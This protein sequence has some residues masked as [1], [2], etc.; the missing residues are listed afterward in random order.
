MQYLKSRPDDSTVYSSL[1]FVVSA[2]NAMKSKNPL[3]E[4]FLVQLDV[5]LEGTGIRAMDNTKAGSGLSHTVKAMVSPFTPDITRFLREVRK[6]VANLIQQTYC[7]DN[8]ECTPVYNIRQSQ[9]SGT[10]NESLQDN[11][12]SRT[13]ARSFLPGATT[14]LPSRHRDSPI[15]DS[16]RGSLGSESQ[17]FFPHVQS[18]NG[19]VELVGQ[20]V[21]DG[22]MDF[23]PDFGVGER[24]PP[25][26][27]PTP[28]TLNSSSNT[29]YSLSGIDNPS[30]DKKHPN[31]AS[32]YPSSSSATSIDKTH[33]V[34]ISPV[35]T[36]ASQILDMGSI[37]GQG[38]PASSAGPMGGTGA[39]YIFNMAN[40]WDM[41][42][43]GQDMGNLD[44]EN[45]NVEAIS[46]AQWAQ[47]LHTENGSG[48]ENWRPS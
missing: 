42:T 20:G 40:R 18:S 9:D 30:P 36:E 5:D 38:Y 7:S 34:Q 14:S 23:L 10:A 37:A 15:R 32:T 13:S 2:L 31:S 12:K 47:I 44:F 21:V 45:V 26:D 39:A 43:P 33:S 4:S 19:I 48:W 1:Q 46:D 28:S 17:Q 25:S 35:A 3:T 41:A 29:S 22:D 8:V 24:N 6:S 27:H 16:E 11:S